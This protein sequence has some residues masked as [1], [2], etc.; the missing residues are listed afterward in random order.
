MVAT[1]R[2]RLPSLNALRAFEAA[3]RHMS[4]KDAAEELN[5]SQSAVSHQV[6]ALEDTLG[7]P[8]FTRGV[9]SIELT[10]RGRL[11]FPVVRSAFDALAE[12]TDLLLSRQSAQSLTLQVYATFTIRWLLPRLARF[13][14]EHP[15]LEIRLT[16]AQSDPNFARDDVD[17]AIIVAAEPPPKLAREYLFSAELFPVCSPGF[18]QRVGEKS[19]PGELNSRQLLQ[20]YPSAEDWRVWLAA[21]NLPELDPEQGLQLESYDVAIGSAVAGMG[22]AL[23]QQP[24]VSRDLAAGTLVEMFPGCRVA[25]PRSWYLVWRRENESDEK[26]LHFLRWMLAEIEADDDLPRDPGLSQPPSG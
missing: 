18:R 22:V 7:F 23:G 15:D 5:V 9:R 2:R 14:A 25:N 6:K 8:L 19:T 12:G 1:R 20:V 16:T 11:Y 13:H 10:R 26:T 24:Y 21:Q 4:F 17:A 3:A